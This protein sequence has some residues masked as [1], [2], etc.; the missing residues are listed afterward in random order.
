MLE[1]L[2]YQSSALQQQKYTLRQFVLANAEGQRKTDE[3]RG[4]IEVK[5]GGERGEA[6]HNFGEA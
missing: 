6:F 3:Q 4:K 1:S 5:D 2:E